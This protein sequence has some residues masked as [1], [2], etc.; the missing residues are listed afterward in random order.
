MSVR[1]VFKDCEC[2]FYQRKGRIGRVSGIM[3]F[4][5]QTIR[6]MYYDVLHKQQAMSNEQAMSRATIHERVT[7][8]TSDEQQ[9]KRRA[10]IHGQSDS[11]MTGEQPAGRVT[12]EEG[13]AKNLEKATSNKQSNEEQAEPRYLDISRDLLLPQYGFKAFINEM[14]SVLAAMAK[15]SLVQASPML[16]PL[17]VSLLL[18][19]FIKSYT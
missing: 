15:L 3:L 13:R 8:A 17:K 11:V 18:N 16:I 19:P 4:S 14:S 12:N 9:A 7:N 1:I 2:G 10:T 5:R 6:R